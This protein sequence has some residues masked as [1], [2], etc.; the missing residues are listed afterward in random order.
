MAWAAKVEIKGS[1]HRHLCSDRHVHQSMLGKWTETP[2]RSVHAHCSPNST[3]LWPGCSCKP[4]L[5][6]DSFDCRLAGSSKHSWPTLGN[7]GPCTVA[8]CT[9]H[10]FACQFQGLFEDFRDLWSRPPPHPCI[11]LQHLATHSCNSRS[12]WGTNAHQVLDMWTRDCWA[13]WWRKKMQLH[14]LCFLTGLLV[15]IYAC[16]TGYIPYGFC[17]C[18]SSPPIV[19]WSDDP[20]GT[21]QKVQTSPLLSPWWSD[22][23]R[24]PWCHVSI[25][26]GCRGGTIF[27]AM[28]S[29]ARTSRLLGPA[30]FH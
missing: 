22:L 14:H 4:C 3:A 25:S 21:L 30:D 5:C 15:I 17:W 27:P 7:T 29:F 9:R 1:W 26:W 23:E 8:D 28:N 13:A 19:S 24:T 10:S 6:Q 20:S 18:N 11:P 2:W 12:L 16:P